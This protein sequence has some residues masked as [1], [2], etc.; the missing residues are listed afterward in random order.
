MNKL[1]FIKRMSDVLE[2]RKANRREN[3]VPKSFVDPLNDEDG[4]LTITGAQ[5][6]VVLSDQANVNYKF[7]KVDEQYLKGQNR[8]NI[9]SQIKK[10]YP[11]AIFFACCADNDNESKTIDTEN[12]FMIIDN[13]NFEAAVDLCGGIDSYIKTML[14]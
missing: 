3:F 1:D 4:E 6:T 11:G 2:K 5:I 13:A 9:I 7:Y 12:N 8:Q 10:Q 14:L